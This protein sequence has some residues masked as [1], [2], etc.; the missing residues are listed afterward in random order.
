M[1]ER[2]PSRAHSVFQIIFMS[3]SLSSGEQ[4]MFLSVDEATTFQKQFIP[5]TLETLIFHPKDEDK[6]LAYTKD[7]KVS[8]GRAVRR[9]P[10][11][12]SSPG[13]PGALGCR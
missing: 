13:D 8:S 6:L 1:P 3:S 9:S 2:V 10:G 4:T 11:D 5:F 12:V 7:S